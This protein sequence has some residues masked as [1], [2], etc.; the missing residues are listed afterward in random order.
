VETG[1][2][3]V[4]KVACPAVQKIDEGWFKVSAPGFETPLRSYTQASAAVFP[5]LRLTVHA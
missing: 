4:L 3:A 2:R 5:T 1:V